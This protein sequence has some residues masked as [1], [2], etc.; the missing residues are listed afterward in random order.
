VAATQQNR[1]VLISDEQNPKMSGYAG[2]PI[3][4]NRR[5]TQP[6]PHAVAASN[7]RLY[8][9]AI[10][11]PASCKSCHWPARAPHPRL[12]HAIAYMGC[13]QELGLFTCSLNRGHH[14]RQ[15][16]KAVIS[17][18]RRRT[19]LQSRKSL[20]MCTSPSAAWRSNT[21]CASR[22]NIRTTGKKLLPRP[23]LERALHLLCTGNSPR[24]PS[25]WLRRDAAAPPFRP[26]FLF[27]SI[28]A[29]HFP[30]TAH[31][32]FILPLISVKSLP[33]AE[34]LR[35]VLSGPG[36]GNPAYTQVTHC[37][38]ITIHTPCPARAETCNGRWPAISASYRF[39]FL[40]R[41]AD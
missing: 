16:R 40:T 8:A 12:G 38:R 1:L 23:A 15:Y 20:A 26:W 17:A 33:R 9:I 14:V 39:S 18:T 24:L 32:T 27:V 25:P 35:Q 5:W 28:V 13:I 4:A 2:H 21:L 30:L 36:V 6:W 11:F 29:P 31:P 41:R 19:T 3:I 7:R 37:D 34:A 22:M 10:C